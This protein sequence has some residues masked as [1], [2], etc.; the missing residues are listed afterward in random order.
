M[1]NGCFYELFSRIEDGS[2]LA[3]L[4]NQVLHKL[5]VLRMMS[6]P[7]TFEMEGKDE[8]CVA[9]FYESCLWEM[10]LHG[11]IEK[12]NRWKNIL[13][14]YE[15]EFGSNWKY[16]ASSKR[17]DSI[18]EY[19]GEDE[20]YDSEGNIRT[21]NLSDKDL[22]CYTV[23]RNLVQDDWRDIVQ[24]TKP[25]HL[26]G[27]CSALQTKAQISI[28]DIFKQA[29]GKEI[30][31]YKQDENGNMIPITFADKA[32]SKASDE[33]QAD[34]LSAMVLY[35]CHCIQFLIDKIR[36]LDEF[37]DNEQELHSIYRDAECLLEM[38]FKD[39]SIFNDLLKSE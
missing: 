33:V 39:M 38:R 15:S 30:S 10:Y 22:E 19:G 25:E 18:K 24:E 17:L 21:M 2:K 6:A 35:I 36:G 11:I 26:S 16:Y 8:H 27:L 4:F 14:E 28:T 7:A 37:A 23:I 20:D 5:D 31:T 13:D 34:N 9:L 32:L 3:G 29:L 12:L 1:K